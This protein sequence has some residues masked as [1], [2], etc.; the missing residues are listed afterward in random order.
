ML[1]KA[2][3]VTA[4]AASFMLAGAPAFATTGD[5]YD[6]HHDAPFAWAWE[7]EETEQDENEEQLGLV[8]LN[9]SQVLSNINV[10]HVDVNVIAIP[11][12][13]GNDEGDCTNVIAN[14]DGPTHND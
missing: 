5:E 9:D 1:K 8:N 10:C 4:I 13:S 14:E 7:S 12:L 6:H 2:A 3:A 11:I